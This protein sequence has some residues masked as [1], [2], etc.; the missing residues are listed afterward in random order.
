M[1][2]HVCLECAKAGNCSNVRNGETVASCCDIEPIEAGMIVW[3][4]DKKHDKKGSFKGSGV[5]KNTG[6]YKVFHD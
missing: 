2:K 4:K 1:I 3:I 5:S 6:L